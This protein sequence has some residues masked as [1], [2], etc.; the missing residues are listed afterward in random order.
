MVGR[1]EDTGSGVP[2]DGR[3]VTIGHGNKYA[4][5]MMG[6]GQGDNQSSRAFRA[7]CGRGIKSVERRIT[8]VKRGRH[9][10]LG[11]NLYV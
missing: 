9:G 5:M 6:P 2:A 3:R 1:N 8:V 10:G 11:I 4:Q 7:R